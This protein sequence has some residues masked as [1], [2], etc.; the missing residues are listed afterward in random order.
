MKKV[1]TLIMVLVFAL[2]L[3][4]CAVVDVTEEDK[5]IKSLSMQS[6][7]DQEMRVGG[8]AYT[9]W[10]NVDPK[11]F[12]DSQIEF[13]SM[14]PDLL[15]IETGTKTSGALWF[16]CTAKAPG[17]TGIYAQTPDESVKSEVVKITI[18]EQ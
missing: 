7:D 3:V 5:S 16:K 13:V 10:V 12:E 6:Q 2:A 15:T 17:I 4:S 8:L 18:L 1:I 14:H 9:S 11:D